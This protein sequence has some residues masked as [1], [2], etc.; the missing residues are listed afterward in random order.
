MHVAYTDS[1]EQLS[2]QLRDYYDKLLDPDTV[3]KL[4]H[5]E[6]VGPDMRRVVKQMGA[7][8]WLGIGWP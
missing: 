2:K 8:G 5:A 7:D 4:R 3:E 1:E 6:G